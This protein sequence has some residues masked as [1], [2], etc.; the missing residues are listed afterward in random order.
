M[1][2]EATVVEQPRRLVDLDAVRRCVL[3]TESRRFFDL[4]ASVDAAVADGAGGMG[5]RGCLESRLTYVSQRSVE[6]S[7][8]GIRLVVLEEKRA[9][10]TAVSRSAPL[11]MLR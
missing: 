5:E 8:P 11:R 6:I 7:A 3:P 2:A 4:I 10:R 1:A 9:D